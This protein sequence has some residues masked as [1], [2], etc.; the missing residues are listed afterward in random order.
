MNDSP[1]KLAYKSSDVVLKEVP[2]EDNPDY[3]L[4]FETEIEPCLKFIHQG[5]TKGVATLI[6]CTA[7][8]S[9]SATICICYL[10][11]Y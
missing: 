5:M 1:L 8:I 6:V 2:L 11:R 4:N 7:G 9:R 10:M 3:L